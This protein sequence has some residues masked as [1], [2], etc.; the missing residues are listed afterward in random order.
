M[1][2]LIYVATLVFSIMYVQ[3]AMAAEAITIAGDPC[4]APLA[5]KL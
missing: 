2:K 5:Q 1:K 3:G 4:T